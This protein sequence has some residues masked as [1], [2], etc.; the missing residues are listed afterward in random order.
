MLKYML[1]PNLV[2]FISLFQILCMKILL[3]HGYSSNPALP[4]L[5]VI[6]MPLTKKSSMWAKVQCGD[7]TTFGL[8][9]VNAESDIQLSC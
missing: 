5:L 3:L 6:K 7:Q 8:T 2:I 1:S 4:Q 9:K